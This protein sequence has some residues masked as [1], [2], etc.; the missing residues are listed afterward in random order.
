MRGCRNIPE[1]QSCATPFEWR[2]PSVRSAEDSHRRV[3]GIGSIYC[4]YHGGSMSPAL[5]ESEV[6]E[7]LPYDRFPIRAGDV[8][9]AA[10]AGQN[11]LVVHRVIRVATKGIR[12]QGDQCRSPDAWSLDQ[13][14]IKGRVVAAWS[15]GRRRRIAGGRV[16]TVQR[17]LARCRYVSWRWALLPL[18]PLYR[19]LACLGVVPRLLPAAFK[20][21]IVVFHSTRGSRRRLF[22]GRHFVGWYDDNGNR[23][24][25]RRPFRL[26]I[27]PAVLHGGQEQRAQ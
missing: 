12:T 22:M 6:L 8:V 13:A 27:N 16:A 20:P 24:E 5:R 21:R 17:R 26:F 25:I 3:A 18:R 9:L 1:K 23:W 10:P 15:G 14:D 11:T 4:L 2:G 7:V 19:G